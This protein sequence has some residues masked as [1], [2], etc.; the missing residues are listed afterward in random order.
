MVLVIIIAVA[1]IVIL[2]P[3]SDE[4][5]LATVGEIGS[6]SHF[7]Q[8]LR[9]LEHSAPQPIVAP[10]YRLRSVDGSGAIH[11]ERPGYPEVAAVRRSSPWW[12]PTSCPGRRWPSWARTRTAAS[13]GRTAIP[14]DRPVDR[15]RATRPVR[16][17]RALSTA[18]MGDAL[19]GPRP[20]TPRRHSSAAAAGTPSGSWPGSSPA[21]CSSGSCPEPRRP[22]WS[23]RC[24]GWP[25]PPTWPCWC[26]CAGLAEEREQKLHY[27]RPEGRRA[28]VRCAPHRRHERTLRPPVQPGCRRPLSPSRRRRHGRPTRRRR[29]ARRP[30]EP[31][32]A[33]LG[34]M[35]HDLRSDDPTHCDRRRGP[36][37][38]TGQGAAHPSLLPALGGGRAGRRRAGRV[39]RPLPGLRSR[40]PRR[41]HRG[42]RPAAE[43]GDAE[44][45]AWWPRTWP[46]SWAVPNPTWPCSTA[47]PGRVGGA[48]DGRPAGPGRRGPGGHLLRPGGRGPGRRPG[49][50][51]RLRDPGVGHRR[52]P[53]PTGCAAGTAMDAG[54]HR[55]L[56]RPRRHG[57]RPRGLGHRGAQPCSAPTPTRSASAARRAPTP[58]GPARRAPR[59]TASGLSRALFPPL[60]RT[61]PSRPGSRPGC[62]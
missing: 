42:G 11:A 32:P 56:G 54:G 55:V 10:A 60:T 52:R 12:A 39:R 19:A 22:G 26:S 43:E 41:A 24:P 51:G 20:P 7:H 45:A 21:P 23:P 27:L 34:R 53:R 1:W 9:V 15:M 46:T 49:R 6:I 3:E 62:G 2:G 58:G 13:A 50:A 61:R 16:R 37:A 38:V 14:P 31:A 30:A 29:S 44:A 8:Q 28:R 36:S 18:A 40:P 4:A 17:P 5:S 35:R 48:A 59:P 47:S 25:W 33:S 57:R